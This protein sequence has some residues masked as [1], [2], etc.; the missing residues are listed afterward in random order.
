MQYVNIFRLARKLGVYNFDVHYE[1]VLNVLSIMFQ[2]LHTCT[3][4]YMSID[5][6]FSILF[7]TMSIVTN[8]RLPIIE[9]FKVFMIICLCYSYC[10]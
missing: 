9:A 1:G 4:I 3:Y 10:H 6:F 2:N 5:P 7:L 8:N